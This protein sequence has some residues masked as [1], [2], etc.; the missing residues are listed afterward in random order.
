MSQGVLLKL[1]HGV[2]GSAD[3]HDFI[4]FICMIRESAR[5]GPTHDAPV[6]DI[7]DN[8]DVDDE[9]DAPWFIDFVHDDLELIN[10]QTKLCI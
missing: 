2:H 10:L 1:F 9:S 8:D 4:R 7:D 6:Y 5:L 3:H